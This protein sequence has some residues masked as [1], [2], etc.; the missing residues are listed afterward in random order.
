MALARGEQASAERWIAHAERANL[1]MDQKIALAG[2]YSRIGRREDAFDLLVRLASSGQP[3][4]M[5]FGDL[6]EFYLTLGKAVEGLVFF[7][8]LRSSRFSAPIAAGWRGWQPPKDM[9]RM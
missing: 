3:P 8:R 9:P 5:V 7:E 2:L 1:A 6:A 4:D